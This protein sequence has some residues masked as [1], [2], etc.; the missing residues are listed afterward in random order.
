MNSYYL[1]PAHDTE[2]E[3]H[4]P[5]PSP[6]HP[7]PRRER[8]DR[9]ERGSERAAA[10]VA[11]VVVVLDALAAAHDPIPQPSQPADD[12]VREGA[13]R[14]RDRRAVLLRLGGRLHRADLLLL[15]LDRRLVNSLHLAHLLRELRR[16]H[17]VPPRVLLHA[18]RGRPERLD[19]ARV[20]ALRLELRL[21]R[22]GLD[23]RQPRGERPR[24]LATP[25]RF[26]L[27]IRHGD[28]R[29]VARDRRLARRGLLPLR[30]LRRVRHLVREVLVLERAREGVSLLQDIRGEVSRRRRHLRGGFQTRQLRRRRLRRERRPMR[31][32]LRVLQR[33]VRAHLVHDRGVHD[34]VVRLGD[35][36]SRGRVVYR[37]EKRAPRE[38]GVHLRVLQ[39]VLR[40]DGPYKR[41]SGWSS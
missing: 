6:L 31:G 30:F 33:S 40:V 21:L 23:P 36:A 15:L 7:P 26:L 25:P 13:R 24:L 19:L 34:A 4:R 3:R 27:Q 17:S 5:P 10:A 9:S 8:P 16:Q 12:V 37:F 29:D 18:R 22:G 20:R 14:R 28:Q 39:V 2:N 38:L 1:S 32:D 35:V 11:V 41:T